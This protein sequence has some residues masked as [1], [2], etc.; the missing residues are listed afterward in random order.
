[1]KFAV[2]LFF[3]ISPAKYI[4]VPREGIFV[5][6]TISDQKKEEILPLTLNRTSDIKILERKTTTT[7][8]TQ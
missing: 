3:A 4:G 1:M 5:K 6:N 2:F 8:A 7:T